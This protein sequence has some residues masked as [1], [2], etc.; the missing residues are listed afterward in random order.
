MSSE[1]HECSYCELVAICPSATPA[2]LLKL[3][4]NETRSLLCTSHHRHVNFIDRQPVRR[5][6]SSQSPA[7]GSLPFFN[8]FF[9]K[10]LARN[11]NCLGIPSKERKMGKTVPGSAHQSSGAVSLFHCFPFHTMCLSYL[12]PDSFRAD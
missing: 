4:N 5:H 6:Q 1:L 12:P 11:W 9:E 2:I 10:K 8:I 7:G 3:T